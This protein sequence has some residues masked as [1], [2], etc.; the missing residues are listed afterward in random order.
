MKRTE[1]GQIG[2]GNP[3]TTSSSLGNPGKCGHRAVR[4]RWCFPWPCLLAHHEDSRTKTQNVSASQRLP[5]RQWHALEQGS[6][7]PPPPRRAT[8]AAA[9]ASAA[10]AHRRVGLH[11]AAEGR[12]RVRCHRVGLVQDDHLKRGARVPRLVRPS[13]HRHLHRTSINRK[14][15]KKNPFFKTL[16]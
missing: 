13:P 9:A 4:V 15:K 6:Q 10:C 14:K 12:L 11:R 1:K 3:C 8:A 5:Q 2:W 7:P 16:L